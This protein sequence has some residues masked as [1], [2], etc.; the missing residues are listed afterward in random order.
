MPLTRAQRSPGSSQVIGD[1]MEKKKYGWTEKGIIGFIFIPMGLIFLIVYAIIEQAGAADAYERLAFMISFGGI[2]AAFFL[3]GV[4]LLYLDLRRRRKQRMAYEGGYKVMAK[5]AGVKSN[6][7][8]NMNGTHP[9]RVECHYTDGDVAH[10]YYSR[11]L[12]VNVADL[13]TADE[14]PV[15]LDRMDDSVGF[16]DIDAV[17]PSIKVHK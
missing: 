5:I 15:Y 11:Y 4:V 1:N 16:V 2:G 17:L 3:I 12:Y 6:N 14:V 13:L 9:V 10:V 7:H 8:V